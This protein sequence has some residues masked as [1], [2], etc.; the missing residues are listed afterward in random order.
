MLRSRSSAC[1]YCPYR[2]G[3]GGTRWGGGGSGG[4]GGG[5]AKSY[6]PKAAAPAKAPKVRASG[7]KGG[8]GGGGADVK[9]K[10]TAAAK[11]AITRPMMAR[12][13]AVFPPQLHLG[14]H[15]CQSVAAPAG[16]DRQ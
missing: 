15:N 11:D 9:G 10:G 14:R 13:N 16:M 5:G 3:N 7:A 1:S 4:G 12:P 8:G 2:R 6:K